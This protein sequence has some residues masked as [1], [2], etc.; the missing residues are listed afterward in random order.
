MAAELASDKTKFLDI[1]E[2]IVQKREEAAE[3]LLELGSG[4][5]HGLV[6]WIPWEKPLEAEDKQK[7]PFAVYAEVG[8]VFPDGDNDEYLEIC[9]RAKRDHVAEVNRMFKDEVPNFEEL[10]KLEQ[11]GS[12]PRFSRI[13]SRNGCASP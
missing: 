13:R 11:G 8:E 2:S 9:R 7:N 5:I 10:D 3:A 12:W 1:G 6:L 4:Q